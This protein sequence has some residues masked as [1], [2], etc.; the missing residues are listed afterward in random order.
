MTFLDPSDY[1]KTLVDET[2]TVDTSNYLFEYKELVQHQDE[3]VFCQADG[4]EYLCHVFTIR[5]VE[6][7]D[8]M[9]LRD[10]IETYYYAI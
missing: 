7:P 9:V 4:K 5:R 2:M 1:D 8:N 6:K 3:K 10:I